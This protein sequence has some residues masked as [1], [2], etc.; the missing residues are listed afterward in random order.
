MRGCCTLPYPGLPKPNGFDNE[1]D[2][3]KEKDLAIIAMA[4]INL[5]LKMSQGIILT[6]PL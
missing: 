2:N 1:K 6:S 4:Q 3:E 5:I